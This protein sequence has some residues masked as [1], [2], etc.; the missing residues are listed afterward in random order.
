VKRITAS[1]LEVIKQKLISGEDISF[2][3]YFSLKRSKQVPKVSK[4]CDNHTRK[5][6]DFKANNKGKGLA[7]FAKSPFIRKLNSETRSCN[8]CKIQKQKIAK[9][10]KLLTRVVSKASS[11]F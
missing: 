8:G 10:T 1:F 5:M 2:K 6:N 7:T 4:L 3:S 9:S 11:S